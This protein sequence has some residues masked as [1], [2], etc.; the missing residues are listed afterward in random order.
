MPDPK[1]GWYKKQTLPY[2]QSLHHHLIKTTLE[3]DQEVIK[4]THLNLELKS[5]NTPCNMAM[6]M[7]FAFSKEGTG[8]F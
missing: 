6:L 5:A 2:V 8:W 4:T 7:P 3:E 1:N